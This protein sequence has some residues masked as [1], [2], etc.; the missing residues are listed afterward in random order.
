[1]I[2]NFA[3]RYNDLSTY[4][5]L[6]TLQDAEKMIEDEIT[7]RLSAAP[8]GAGST[9]ARTNRFGASHCS[10]AAHLYMSSGSIPRFCW[11]AQRV[12]GR[13]TGAALSEFLFKACA[14]YKLLGKMVFISV[15]NATKGDTQVLLTADN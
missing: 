10:L 14:K 15:Y 8:Y 11:P 1:M 2:P 13:H 9:D 7:R 5:V 3:P 12:V 6:S 4:M